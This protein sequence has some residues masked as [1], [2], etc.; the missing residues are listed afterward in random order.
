MPPVPKALKAPVM[1]NQPA[2]QNYKNKTIPLG[3]THDCYSA[4][5]KA[6][7]YPPIIDNIVLVGLLF[8]S[9]VA[10]YV[11]QK[12]YN[13]A[14]DVKIAPSEHEEY[15]DGVVKNACQWLPSKEG[16]KKPAKPVSGYRYSGQSE[17][18]PNNAALLISIPSKAQCKGKPW[19]VRLEFNPSKI[20]DLEELK[21]IAAVWD[22]IFLGEIPFAVWMERAQITALDVAIDMA[23]V[24]ITDLFVSAP[25][26][27]K[28]NYWL[29]G[30]K[31][32][33]TITAWKFA[34]GKKRKLFMIYDKQQELLDTG[35]EL[36]AGAA[37]RV[38]IERSLRN[39]KIA[40]HKL[41]ALGNPFD[42]LTL[43]H[44]PTI[45]AKQSPGFRL[46]VHAAQTMGFVA[47]PKEAPGEFRAQWK[48]A[49]EHMK[50]AAFWS[51][52][53]SW[54]HWKKKLKASGIQTWI[55][56]A[57]QAKLH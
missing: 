13:L 22:K 38:R 37:H 26:A 36:F 51:P 44:I 23:G 6:Y 21:A 16:F 28:W 48:Q 57:K 32:A 42:G 43:H 50:P 12:N 29:S 35:H 3:R 17:I 15:L 9:D 55:D 34:G 19:R 40:L 53:T 10:K 33:Q 8:Q 46:F 27:N 25:L 18:G 24:P 41:D 30:D 54:K 1:S 52:E 49:V 31:E 47:A 45:A 20:G 4:L 7:V 14:P 39:Q 2:N 11:G 56:A 5:C